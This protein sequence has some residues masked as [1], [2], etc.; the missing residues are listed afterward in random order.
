M[1]RKRARMSP[2]ECVRVGEMRCCSSVCFSFLSETERQFGM[3]AARFL[4]CKLCAHF[5]QVITLFTPETI[6]YV[7]Q[8]RASTTLV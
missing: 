6:L 1:K 3:S 2:C 5:L 4:F 8:T 7:Q